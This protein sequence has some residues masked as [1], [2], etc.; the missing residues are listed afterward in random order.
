MSN[1]IIYFTVHIDNPCFAHNVED[2][3]NQLQHICKPLLFYDDLV[4][5]MIATA[6]LKM[7]SSDIETWEILN[8]SRYK[9][10]EGRQLDVDFRHT[11]NHFVARN[12]TRNSCGLKTP[13][14]KTI[15]GG[16]IDKP[17]SKEEKREEVAQ[18]L[19]IHV[20]RCMHTFMQQKE[21]IGH[22]FL[23][24]VYLTR[25][26]QKKC[27]FVSHNNNNQWLIMM[28]KVYYTSTFLHFRRR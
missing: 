17:W 10:F 21:V 22:D 14:L 24:Q 8:I 9:R 23:L 4:N 5:K 25:N 6:F 12:L 15:Y 13:F 3:K 11:K 28:N 16:W 27:S 7:K 18:S 1:S 20:A 2:K 26:K 19:S